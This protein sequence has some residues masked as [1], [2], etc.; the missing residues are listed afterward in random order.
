V[1]KEITR[2]VKYVPEIRQV[3]D[4]TLRSRREQKAILDRLYATKYKDWRYEKEVRVNG[5]RVE[6]DEETGQYFVPFTSRLRLKVVIA[7]ARFP[8]AEKV[9]QDAL[10]GYSEVQ[11]FKARASTARFEILRGRW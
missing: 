11:S 7:G 4:L 8:M 6:R 1:P 9:I 2:K 10:E 3:D 5:S